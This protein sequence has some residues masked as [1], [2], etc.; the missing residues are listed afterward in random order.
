MYE[1]LGL[2]YDQNVQSPKP[3]NYLTQVQQQKEVHNPKNHH[4]TVKEFDSYA[5][6]HTLNL[7][8]GNNA[9]GLRQKF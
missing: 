3:L 8:S 4:P 5:V 9:S 7:R 1:L 2:A 6:Y